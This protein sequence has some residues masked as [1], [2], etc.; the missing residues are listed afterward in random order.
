MILN[1]KTTVL[2]T[3]T[4]L[5]LLGS[6][7]AIAD[8]PAYNEIAAFMIQHSAAL[9]AEI[10]YGEESS[11]LLKDE[12]L[13]DAALGHK[14]NWRNIYGSHQLIARVLGEH[15]VLLMCDANG[16]VALLEDS[17][18]TPSFDKYRYKARSSCDITY[19]AASICEN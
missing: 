9:E 5:V 10:A 4:A 3:T 2:A 17:S 18:C 7:R 19:T 13:L 15:T 12:A 8:D 11:K 14:P 6:C 16:Q 1:L